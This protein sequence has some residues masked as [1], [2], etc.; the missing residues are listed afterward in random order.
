V[1]SVYRILTAAQWAEAERLGAVRPNDLD[2]ASGF[3]H[4][5]A[6][7]QLFET[8]DR[9]FTPEVEPVALELDPDSLGQAL[10]WEP[11]ASRGGALFPH[12]Y[13]DAIGLDLVRAVIPLAS[14]DATSRR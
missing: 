1:A 13:A 10:R 8:A 14:P 4:L 3:L 6:E 7:D 9:Y 2:R 12:L 11:V 5:S